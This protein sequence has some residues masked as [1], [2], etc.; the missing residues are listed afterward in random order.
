MMQIEISAQPPDY[1]TIFIHTR[2][3]DPGGSG[4]CEP[5][6][7]EPPT[8]TGGGSTGTNT[9]EPST[10]PQGTHGGGGGGFG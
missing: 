4:T 8:N 9:E 5:Q 3:S 6:P 1:Q 10:D 7:T 2:D